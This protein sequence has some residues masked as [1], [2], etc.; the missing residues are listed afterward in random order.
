MEVLDPIIEIPELFGPLKQLKERFREREQQYE[1]ARP[2]YKSEYAQW[3]ISPWSWSTARMMIENFAA[4]H[5]QQNFYKCVSTAENLLWYVDMAE[6]RDQVVNNQIESWAPSYWIFRYIGWLMLASLPDKKEPAIN[7]SITDRLH[8][9][10][11][12]TL[13]A[14]L[15]TQVLA[16]REELSYIPRPMWHMPRLQVDLP[17]WQGA[18]PLQYSETIR[19]EVIVAAQVPYHD[20]WAA[21]AYAIFREIRDFRGKNPD[22]QKW[23][24]WSF[25]IPPY[26]REPNWRI[27]A[28]SRKKSP[29]LKHKYFT[30]ADAADNGWIQDPNPEDATTDVFDLEALLEVLDDDD[31]EFDDLT[32]C[33]LLGRQ[34]R[35]GQDD[36]RASL[37]DPRTRFQVGKLFT[38]YRMADISAYDGRDDTPAWVV[39]GDCVFDITEYQPKDEQHFEWLHRS[40]GSVLA[41]DT[42]E[43]KGYLRDVL[44][45][46]LKCQI[47]VLVSESEVQPGPGSTHMVF[48]EATLRGYDN[49]TDGVYTAIGE[50]V[51]KL[52]D[53]ID[54]HPGGAVAIQP[55]AGRD[56]TKAFLEHHSLELLLDDPE[57]IAC[58]IGRLVDERDEGDID[59]DEIAI[60][61]SIF[62]VSGLYT[63]DRAL[64]RL[65]MEWYGSDATEIL[66]EDKPE[67]AS[68]RN[69]LT[70]FFLDRK[71]C[72]V[73]KIRS[74]SS[75]KA[76]REVTARDVAK[77]GEDNKHAIWVSVDDDVFD[78]TA[79]VHHPSYFSGS[80]RLASSDAGGAV[81]SQKTAAWLREN[82]GHR[83]VARLV[84]HRHDSVST[85]HLD[86]INDRERPTK[87]RKVEKNGLRHEGVIRALKKAR[88]PGCLIENN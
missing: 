78:V 35:P 43:E 86:D 54:N 44:E 23:A 88:R 41:T 15:S 19:E 46:L 49:P 14:P 7:P 8:G 82:H 57:F 1:T 74:S 75:E 87:R 26:R 83:I 50:Y 2:W 27:I 84:E 10:S 31:L 32:V 12:V 33:G 34:L 59:E 29:F 85:I 71:D 72:V 65:L 5:A 42:E 66:T 39:C 36:I 21:A 40:A 51:Y 22:K 45:G 38:E 4:Y 52:T 77:H 81:S 56:G 11:Q 9:P 70:R 24:P 61:G 17:E 47:G 60:H 37:R 20:D 68:L 69:S 64:H 58:R 63:E 18:P 3:Q 55:V 48:T 30:V 62:N 13:N 73:A 6:D 53:Y 67:Y 28:R 80:R 76:L 16:H 79:L 25:K